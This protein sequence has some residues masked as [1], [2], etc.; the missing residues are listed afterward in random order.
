MTIAARAVECDVYPA[1]LLEDDIEDTI[2]DERAFVQAMQDTEPISRE[3][4]LL[5]QLKSVTEF[6]LDHDRKYRFVS[7]TEKRLLQSMT[8]SRCADEFLGGEE[9]TVHTVD[10][11]PRGSYCEEQR[12]FSLRKDLPGEENAY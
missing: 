5:A 9:L 8:I 1:I 4:D 6:F 10:R 2:F 11:G 12:A 3:W 7:H